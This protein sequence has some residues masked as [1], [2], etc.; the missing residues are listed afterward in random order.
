VF[1]QRILRKSLLVKEK[2]LA[3]N[4]LLYIATGTK[5][6]E[7]ALRSIC[8]VRKC[9]PEVEICLYTDRIPASW[10]ELKVHFRKLQKPQFCSRDKI[11]PLCNPP[12]IAISLPFDRLSLRAILISL[13]Y[14]MN[15]IYV[16]STVIWL[17]VMPELRCFMDV[18]CLYERL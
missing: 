12:F 1:L 11:E 18:E 10:P 2:F 4:G 6:R 15:I 13:F 14:Q 9:M 16:Q 17:V 3:K 8:S 7:E 5:F